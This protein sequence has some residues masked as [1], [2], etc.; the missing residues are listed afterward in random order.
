MKFKLL[1]LFLFCNIFA[2]SQNITITGKSLNKEKKFISY[3]NNYYT[4]KFDT[5]WLTNTNT[6][7]LKYKTIS[8]YNF[9][10]I[11]NQE[12][13]LEQG[14]SIYVIVH[15]DKVEVLGGSNNSKINNVLY[16][17]YSSDNFDVNSYKDSTVKLFTENIENW[18]KTSNT[19]LENDKI[20]YKLT[21]EQYDFFKQ[22]ILL[23]YV[24]Y[25]QLFTACM[26]NNQMLKEDFTTYIPYKNI[27]NHERYINFN[28]TIL[29]RSHYY[30][31][32]LY[33]YFTNKSREK[34]QEANVLI[35]NILYNA[36]N[37]NLTQSNKDLYLSIIC[38]DLK[39]TFLS[40]KN[41]FYNT[42]DSVFDYFSKN[43]FEKENYIYFKNIYDKKFGFKKPGK[44]I[45]DIPLLDTLGNEVKLSNYKDYVIYIDL[46]GTWCGGCIASI[47]DFNKLTEIFKNEKVLFLS[48]ALEHNFENKS[49]KDGFNYWKKVVKNKGFK[50]L[51][52]ISLEGMNNPLA[53]GCFPSYILIGKNGIIENLFAKSP[54]E[55]ENQ[56]KELLKK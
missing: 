24:Y 8:K 28:D 45:S 47:P 20:Q 11:E 4:L 35:N 12:F 5:L 22:F 41:N 32:V 33:Y 19:H 52:S 27:N 40:S 48:I 43:Y 36:K 2:F 18:R 26:Y 15:K 29:N 55:A 17:K 13:L 53:I 10:F 38:R 46:W 25:H 16:S 37:N 49:D 7:N 14:D 54:T 30:Y 50:G 1:I 44:Q 51:A 3:C 21:N 23:E 34:N 56:I 39:L 31:T 6:F 9:I 42:M